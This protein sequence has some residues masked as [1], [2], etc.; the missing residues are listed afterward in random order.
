MTRSDL[1]KMTRPAP[2]EKERRKGR[3]FLAFSPFCGCVFRAKK[4]DRHK[5][6]M[7]NL[8]FKR[9]Q[10]CYNVHNTTILPSFPD[11]GPKCGENRE[12]IGRASG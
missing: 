9:G 10:L 5:K 11:S 6:F 1:E 2:S 8:F 4:A 3:A 7:V 12:L